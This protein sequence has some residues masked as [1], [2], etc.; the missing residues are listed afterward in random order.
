VP[1]PEE[2]FFDE[3]DTETAR[4]SVRRYKDLKQESDRIV[5]EHKANMAPG[6][7]NVRWV[8]IAQDFAVPGEEVDV[9]LQSPVDGVQRSTA[10]YAQGLL[11]SLDAWSSTPEH[12]RANT[13]IRFATMLEEMTRREPF[14][15]TAFESDSEDMVVLDR[16]PFYTLCA[17]HVVPFYGYAYVG[18]VPDGHIAGLSKFARAVQYCAKGFHVQEELTKEIADFLE[19]ELDPAGIAVV[20]RAEH[21]CMAM[22]GAQVPGVMTTTSRMTGVFADHNR[23]A[24]AEFMSI[25]KESW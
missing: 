19:A 20:M 6:D 13:P 7:S 18:Y 25:I 1:I 17:H 16:I 23:T 4:Q 24:K 11:S 9:L 14:K 8:G 15:F 12:H 5:A 10:D 2:D 22:R 3:D 21:L